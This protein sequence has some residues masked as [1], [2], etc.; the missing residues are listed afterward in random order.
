MIPIGNCAAQSCLS[1][2]SLFSEVSW[3]QVV[4]LAG[5]NVCYKSE[6]MIKGDEDFWWYLPQIADVDR[7]VAVMITGN[8]IQHFGHNSSSR[9]AR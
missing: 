2:S 5:C 3:Q 8:G 1:A 7:G 4:E 9:R 6:L